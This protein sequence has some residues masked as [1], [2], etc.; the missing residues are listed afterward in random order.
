[1][2]NLYPFSSRTSALDL[3]KAI[4]HRFKDDKYYSEWVLDGK[5][6]HLS[7]EV[8]PEILDYVAGNSDIFK[9]KMFNPFLKHSNITSRFVSKYTWLM[10]SAK[11]YKGKVRIKKP[12]C[13]K[14]DFT[15]L[16]ILLLELRFCVDNSIEYLRVPSTFIVK[17]LTV[18]TTPIL[19][20]GDQGVYSVEKLLE[21]IGIDYRTIPTVNG[22]RCN[23]KE[24]ES[25]AKGCNYTT[26]LYHQEIKVKLPQ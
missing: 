4:L 10:V 3:E 18:R 19:T 24:L 6:E 2:K 23:L 26:I 16:K 21:F 7:A 5:R 13:S 11:S 22:V 8:L 1:M 17:H 14:K 15:F 9:C 12:T 25:K 20:Q